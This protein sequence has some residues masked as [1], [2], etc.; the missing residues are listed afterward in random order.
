[1]PTD[2][3]LNDN[4]DPTDTFSVPGTVLTL[5]DGRIVEVIATSPD[6]LASG[7]AINRILVLPYEKAPEPSQDTAVSEYLINGI[8]SDL[9]TRMATLVKADQ[10]FELDKATRT[11]KDTL[12][13][14][15]PLSEGE[16]KY[17]TVHEAFQVYS[18]VLETLPNVLPSDI[19]SKVSLQGRLRAAEWGITGRGTLTNQ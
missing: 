4:R 19:A 13:G 18:S 2:S 5:S 7:E 9:K 10:S 11:I 16:T 3:E 17:K 15:A 6:T 1:M 12:S 14:V 8:R